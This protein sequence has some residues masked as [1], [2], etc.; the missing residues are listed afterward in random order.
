MD[1]RAQKQLEASRGRTWGFGGVSGLFL[2]LVFIS[3]QMPVRLA[4]A[5]LVSPH[6]RLWPRVDPRVAYDRP[7]PPTLARWCRI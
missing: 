4:F 1:P 2:V 3:P 7:N 5:D 6:G